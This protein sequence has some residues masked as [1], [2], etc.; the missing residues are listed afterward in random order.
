MQFKDAIYTTNKIVELSLGI[1]K[2]II[3]SSEQSELK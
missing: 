1:L 2:T 3:I